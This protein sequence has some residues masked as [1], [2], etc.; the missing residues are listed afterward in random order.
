[1]DW[2]QVFTSSLLTVLPWTTYSTSPC[3]RF[4]IRKQGWYG[5]ALTLLLFINQVIHESLSKNA[6]LAHDK[7]YLHN[8][9]FNHYSRLHSEKAKN[10]KQ[11]RFPEQVCQKL[12][13]LKNSFLTIFLCLHYS[14]VQERLL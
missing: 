14:R 10:F 11:K 3:L 12:T 13:I 5:K 7:H 8:S 1:M 4:F 6:C 9:H 2:V